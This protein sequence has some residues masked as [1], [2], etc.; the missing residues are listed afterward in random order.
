MQVICLQWIF[1]HHIF[2]CTYSTHHFIF[3]FLSSHHI[4]NSSHHFI[5][6]LSTQ[7]IQVYTKHFALLNNAYIYYIYIKT[8]YYEIY[9]TAP[10]SINFDSCFLLLMKDKTGISLPF[11]ALDFFHFILSIFSHYTLLPKT[12]TSFTSRVISD[13]F[14]EKINF[15]QFLEDCT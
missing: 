9:F 14:H 7:G 11:D 15:S 1:E 3:L 4:T 13:I 2:L 8:I 6:S 10:N 5:L 12:N